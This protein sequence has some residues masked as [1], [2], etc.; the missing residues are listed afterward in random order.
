MDVVS[1]LW[2]F[3][4]AI[5]LALAIL[6]GTLWLIE[7]RAHASLI[8]CVVGVSAAAATV[9][10]LQ[11]MHSATTAEYGEWLRWDHVPNFIAIVGLA[12]FVRL[13]LGTGRLAL[14]WAFISA[15]ALVLILNFLVRP[16]FNFREIVSLRKVS[17]LGEQVSTIG[18]A[19]P[20]TWQ[21]F[22]VASLVLLFVYLIDAVV[23]RWRQG[24]AESRRKALAVGL[25]I[26][27]PYLF[28]VALSQMYVFGIVHIPLYNL[29]WYLGILLMMAYELGHDLSVSRRAGLELAELR[30]Q[31]A[32]V[33]RVNMLGQLSSTLAHELTQPLTAALLNVEAA[34][35][36]LAGKEPNLKELSSIIDDIGRDER[37]AA[38]LITRMRMLSKRRSIEI[39]P[40]DMEDVVR[41]VVALVRPQATAKQIAVDV[42]MSSRLPR[43]LGDRVHLTQVLL[44][45]IM[46]GIDAV[47]SRPM[48]ARRIVIEVRADEGTSQVEVAVMDSGPGVSEAAARQIFKPFFTTKENGMGLGLALCRTIVEAHGGKLWNELRPPQDGATFRFTLRA[49]SGQ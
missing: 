20:R 21:W 25:G 27:T 29:V 12:L 8:L 3:G 41:D 24:G 13:Y 38:D 17:L 48:D 14:L 31:L 49:L 19:V 35:A 4:A 30:G 10:E 40:L 1:T 16:N 23:E 9:I 42:R 45:L 36:V 43:V 7:R 37:R 26:V 15:R 18:M 33:E 5:Q 6:C 11:M 2:L 47:E 22:A 34:Q 28:N 46:N 39:Q 32:Q 44:N